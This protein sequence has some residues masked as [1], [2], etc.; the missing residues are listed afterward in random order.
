MSQP[1]PEPRWEGDVLPKL[2]EDE[3]RRVS[4]K[5]AQYRQWTPSTA[6]SFGR[7]HQADDDPWSTPKD[8]E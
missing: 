5:R 4:N 1:I 7:I 6:H 3:N 8:A 2:V